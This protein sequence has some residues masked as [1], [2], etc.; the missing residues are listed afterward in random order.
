MHLIPIKYH[1]LNYPI[2]IKPTI[3]EVAGHFDIEFLSSDLKDDKFSLH[4]EYAA[5]LR[6]FDTD[7]IQS[8]PEIISSSTNRGVPRL[9]TSEK[10]AEE[11]AQFLIGLFDGKHPHIIEIH[12]PRINEFSNFSERYKIFYNELQSNNIKSKILIENRNGFGLS[13]I[14][15]FQ[16][17]SKIID[18]DK[19]NL[20][21]ILDFPQLFNFEE[22]RTD[23]KKL[24]QV[25]NS[26][27]GFKHNVDAFHIWGQVGGS[28]HRGDLNDYFNNNESMKNKFLK[29]L[30]KLFVNSDKDIYFI[31][32]INA[33]HDNCTREKCL[34]NIVEDLEGVGFK[35]G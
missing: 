12:P 29:L 5:G 2:H 35:F 13:G 24:E 22:A 34:S 8:F 25:M 33:G 19:L 27:D 6:R 26:I 16:S 7:I 20:K 11:F 10:W 21:L 1:N 17:F 14:D 30:A 28:S 9:W 31:P 23:I 18:D 15:N 32:E 3:K 4:T